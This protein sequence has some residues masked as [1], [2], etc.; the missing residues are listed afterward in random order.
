MPGTAAPAPLR[1]AR[2]KDTLG[3][4]FQ[5]T[6]QGFKLGALGLRQSVSMAFTGHG[7]RPHGAG[8]PLDVWA[9]PYGGRAGRLGA[10]RAGHRLGAAVAGHWFAEGF[11]MADLQEARA[12]LEALAG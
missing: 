6:G 5:S 10:W 11:D 1:A 8:A 2:E 3:G 9:L 7:G 12:L 4:R